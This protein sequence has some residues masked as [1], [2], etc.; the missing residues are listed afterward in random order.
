MTCKLTLKA[1]RGDSRSSEATFVHHVLSSNRRNVSALGKMFYKVTST[2]KSIRKQKKL[3]VV[4]QNLVL[5]D[6]CS[7]CVQRS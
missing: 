6:V 4:C 5:V 7:A 3:A 2:T 1:L